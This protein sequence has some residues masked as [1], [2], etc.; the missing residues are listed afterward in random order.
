MRIFRFLGRN[1][2]TLL[3][4]F[5]LALA[6]WVLAVISTDPSQTQPLQ[7]PVPITIIGQD[8][9]LMVTN[10][11]AKETSV[12]LRAPRSVWA[13]INADP[14]S[15]RAILDLSGLQSGQH[16]VPLQVQIAENPAVVV[17]S[18][19]DQAD[20]NL[21]GIESRILPVG[22]RTD[23]SPAPGFSLGSTILTPQS[24]SVSG[25]SSMV[26]RVVGLQTS[27]QL[28]NTSKT[29]DREL[30]ILALDEAGNVVQGVQVIP[31]A[32]QVSQFIEQRGGYRTVVV[33]VPF[34][35]QLAN[36][37][38]LNSVTVTPPVLT[39]FSD[40]PKLVENLP[41]YIETLPLDLTGINT[42]TEIKAKL[43]MPQGIQMDGDESVQIRLGISP[44]EGSLTF[45][46]LSVEI[47][48]LEAGLSAKVSPTRVDVIISGPLPLLNK[49][50]SNDVR[51]VLDLAGLTIGNYQI[52]PVAR[53]AVDGL[54]V[55]SIL[56][57]TLEVII[58][59]ALTPTP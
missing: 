26:S 47:E 25:P 42:D 13:R 12:V 55:D 38:R 31:A 9:A 8:P 20:V 28:E 37:Y 7:S 57:D 39:V 29:I 27:M 23:G 16:Q 6:V 33:R 32:V 46:N 49:L 45:A 15:V 53:I 30:P 59:P 52:K 43:N 11:I 56:P 22:Y 50:T 44:L 35:G 4:A 41:G 40:D 58:T 34:T 19:I 5:L 1:I 24:A 36:G 18:S 51:V 48:G 14:S 21:E 17:S 10:T 3:T 54:K 2:S